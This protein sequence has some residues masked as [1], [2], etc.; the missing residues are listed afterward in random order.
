MAALK[1][2]QAGKLPFLQSLGFAAPTASN[3]TKILLPS[4]A[5]GSANKKPKSTAP[6]AHAST[7]GASAG[8]QSLAASR[9]SDSVRS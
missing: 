3:T 1:T 7:P 5:G 9:K 4:G 6:T 8:K 2:D